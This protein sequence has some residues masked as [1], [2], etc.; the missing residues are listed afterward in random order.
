MSLF[1]SKYWVIA[2]VTELV[3]YYKELGFLET[4]ELY[5]LHPKSRLTFQKGDD[6]MSIQEYF[7]YLLGHLKIPLSTILFH[8]RP[9][10]SSNRNVKQWIFPF[11][12]PTANE[13]AALLKVKKN[14]PV[15]DFIEENGLQIRQIE[16]EVVTFESY[17]REQPFRSQYFQSEVEKAMAQQEATR[18]RSSFVEEGLE[19][20]KRKEGLETEPPVLTESERATEPPFFLQSPCTREQFNQ[21]MSEDTAFH[22]YKI[23]QKKWSSSIYISS[24]RVYDAGNGDQLLLDNGLFIGGFP[25][26][27]EEREQNSKIF[28][29]F[30]ANTLSNRSSVVWFFLDLWIRKNMVCCKMLERL[31]KSQDCQD[32]LALRIHQ[33][34]KP[35]KP[36]PIL[37]RVSLRGGEN[38][39]V[40]KAEYMYLLS[41]LPT[42]Y[43]VLREPQTAKE[44]RK[45]IAE[46]QFYI[47]SHSK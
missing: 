26:L 18:E 9:S 11:L 22:P 23:Y 28:R 32:K 42:G 35:Q 1:E 5:T 40:L 7:K 47:L 3:L 27:K 17:A 44:Y 10:A 2:L 19:T 46:L 43:T 37:K 8:P 31:L 38:L 25:K 6:M 36:K 34:Q 33:P 4:C 30:T 12:V 24:G 13:L 39:E 45:S 41:Q 20:N 29:P 21:M 14:Q 16:R 15:T